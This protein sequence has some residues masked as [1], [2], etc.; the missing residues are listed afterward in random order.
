MKKALA[1]MLTVLCFYYATAAQ[2]KTVTNADLEKYR[3]E[4]LKKDPDDERE[5][6]RLGLPS[7]EAEK[8]ARERQA[9]EI[10]EIAARIRAQQ[11]EAEDYWREQAFALRSDIAAVEAEINYVRAR[12]G[13]IP[14]PQTYYAIGYNPYFYS[15]GCCFSHGKKAAIGK[16]NGATRFGKPP[17]VSTGTG[18]ARNLFRQKQSVT[19]NQFSTVPNNLV[20]RKSINRFGYGYNGVLVVPFTLPTY[21]NLTRE[22][23]LARLRLLEQTRAGLLAR[24]AVLEDEAFKNGVRLE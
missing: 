18:Y 16:I 21:E 2:T 11:I 17:V 13:E 19:L 14:S 5:R 3:R 6:A 23:L 24:F 9:A 7:R 20:N 10:A 4:R 1:F 8:Q 22:E 15:P 12:I